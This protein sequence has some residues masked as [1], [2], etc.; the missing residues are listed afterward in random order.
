MKKTNFEDAKKILSDSGKA[1]RLIASSDGNWIIEYLPE[2]QKEYEIKKNL[3][4]ELALKKQKEEHLKKEK[5][6]KQKILFE[7]MKKVEENNRKKEELKAE[8]DLKEFR[9]RIALKEE[10][11]RLEKEIIKEL[12]VEK[13]RNR[14]RE[15]F[16]DA[17]II[18]Q[19]KRSGSGGKRFQFN[20]WGCWIIV[21]KGK[22]IA[23]HESRDRVEIAKK[24]KTKVFKN[25][26]EAIRYCNWLINHHWYSETEF[27]KGEKDFDNFPITKT[28]TE[29][30]KKNA[31][32]DFIPYVKLFS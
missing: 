12:N 18:I 19:Y 27:F 10:K 7:K 25:K 1:G 20:E 21:K 31:E 28:L 16:S 24:S 3:I 32:A 29:E 2:R 14:I 23:S 26:T 22:Y 13:I 15:K 8:K 4:D 11:E 5:L 30:E 9:E 6:K 17:K